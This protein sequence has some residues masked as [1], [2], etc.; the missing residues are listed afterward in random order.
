MRQSEL[1][2]RIIQDNQVAHAGPGGAASNRAP[3]PHQDFQARPGALGGASRADN[4]GSHNDNVKGWAQRRMPQ[5]KGSFGSR[6]RVDSALTKALP[7]IAGTISL[8]FRP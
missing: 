6:I 7:V 5:Q 8:P 2:L 1:R 4:A 3:V